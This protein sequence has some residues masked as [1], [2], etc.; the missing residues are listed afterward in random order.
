MIM[1]A[2]SMTQALGV[3]GRAD[4]VRWELSTVELA[5]PRQRIGPLRLGD[6]LPAWSMR[7][8]NAFCCC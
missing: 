1:S 3:K 6:L 4:S 5:V 2:W 8:G 7:V